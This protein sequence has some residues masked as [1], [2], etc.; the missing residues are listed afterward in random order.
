MK[1]GKG[2]FIDFVKKN[3][4]VLFWLC[5]LYILLVI[6]IDVDSW[7]QSILLFPINILSWPTAI[8]VW[9][10]ENS[11]SRTI[12]KFCIGLLFASVV[13]PFFALYSFATLHR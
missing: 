1:N 10:D 5:W 2:A 13:L 4:G 12:R 9:Q 7:M 8:A 6:S 11:K 3:C